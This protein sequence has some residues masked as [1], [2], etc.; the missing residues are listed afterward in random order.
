MRH[1]RKAGGDD[2]LISLDD[3]KGVVDRM[4]DGDATAVAAF[5]VYKADLG[6]GLANLATFYNPSLIVPAAASRTRDY[7]GTRRGGGRRS[8]ACDAWSGKIVQS[9]LGSDC[10]AMGAAYLVLA[11]SIARMMQGPPAATSEAA[12]AYSRVADAIVAVGLT[13]IDSTMV[14][15]QQPVPDTKRRS[16]LAYLW[17]RQCRQLGGRGVTPP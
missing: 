3:A 8:I 5:R 9:A 17:G 1:W 10:A 11:E 15:T 13:C 16:A 2:K 12:S 7:D 6:T 4:R 14:V